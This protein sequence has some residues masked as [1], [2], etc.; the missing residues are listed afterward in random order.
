MFGIY[1][2]MWY[3]YR[4]SVWSIGN[5]AIKAV[6]CDNITLYI[7]GAP[8]FDWTKNIFILKCDKFVNIITCTGEL[9]QI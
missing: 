7:M 3:G 2:H 1:L 9:D 6:R 4:L 5:K 8:N